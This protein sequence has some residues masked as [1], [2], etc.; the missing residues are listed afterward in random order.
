MSN[1][2]RKQTYRL[3]KDVSRLK[4]ARVA[5]QPSYRPSRGSF[6]RVDLLSYKQRL[7][8]E[9]KGFGFKTG[10][11]DKLVFN[12]SKGMKNKTTQVALIKNDFKV[13]NLFRKKK[14]FSS[15]FKGAK[16]SFKGLFAEKNRYNYA[17]D[18]SVKFG[19]YSQDVRY[20][21]TDLFDKKVIL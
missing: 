3:S 11:L 7:P 8:V 9:R 16:A 19:G 17:N 18:Y 13:T 20:R 1:P 5:G 15:E 4:E 6:D 2:F 21:D 10:Y 12:D 14:K